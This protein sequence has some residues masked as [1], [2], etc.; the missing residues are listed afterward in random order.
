MSTPARPSRI[1]QLAERYPVHVLLLCAFF[2][3]HGR[4]EHPVSVNAGLTLR[5]MGI[6]MLVAA[7]VFLLARPFLKSNV[8]AGLF[9]FAVLCFQL[10]FQ[11]AYDLLSSLPFL[12]SFF[13]IRYFIG[14]AIAA[15]V[16]LFIRLRRSKSEPVKFTA[17]LNLLTCIFVVSELCYWPIQTKAHPLHTTHFAPI[18]PPIPDSCAKPDIYLLLMDAYTSSECLRTAR[19]YDNSD[20]DNFL[21]NN[22][23]KI[24]PYSR[25]NY[26]RTI[27]SM[28]SVL[29]MGYLDNV[30]E[31]I[32]PNEQITAERLYEINNNQVCKWLAGNG[33]E[34]V[35]FS[36]F[37]V[38]GK[39]LISDDHSYFFSKRKLITTQT[40]SSYV[41]REVLPKIAADDNM[42]VNK[43]MGVYTP[44]FYN[45]Q[46]TELTLAEAQRQTTQPRFV[47]SHLLMP[48]PPFFYDKEGKLRERKKVIDHLGYGMQ[49]YLDYLTPANKVAEELITTILS[50]AKRPTVIILM[51]DHG[52]SYKKEARDLQ[53]PN[54][55][56]IYCSDG[57]YEGLSDSVTGV[58][59]FRLLFN[60]R[61]HTGLPKIKDAT[62]TIY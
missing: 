47:Y 50:H 18:A 42:L 36:P 43:M 23:F 15:L 29:N 35:N 51:G 54:Y 61:F 31:K 41:A 53:F 22:G 9:S 5:L 10:F 30:W 52:Y 16:L 12:K 45:R 40:F 60:N 4:N 19:G 7:G 3:L 37:E 56:A 57:N 14:L 33:Y 38:A 32:V 39:P 13:H 44:L 24:L 62:I 48:H 55:N 8:K 21:R 28:S 34:I 27:F 6:Y 2:V 17:F 59:Q 46:I 58:N 49:P 1:R 20:F 26:S 11:S 25:S